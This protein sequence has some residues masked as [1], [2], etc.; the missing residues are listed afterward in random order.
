M[1][2]DTTCKVWLVSHNLLLDL[3]RDYNPLVISLLR[4]R[5]RFRHGP[6]LP[7]PETL[8]DVAIVTTVLVRRIRL[9]HVMLLW[10]V[11]KFSG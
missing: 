3:W 8:L 2:E 11:G 1:P 9:L 5:L 4:H 6:P 7:K 10:K